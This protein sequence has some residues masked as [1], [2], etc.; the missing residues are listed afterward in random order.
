[1]EILDDYD[2]E[3]CQI[4]YN[5]VNEDVQ[6]GTKGL[7]YAAAKGLGVIVMEPLFGGTLANPPQPV[8]EIWKIST[9][10]GPPTWP[11]GGSGTS[12]RCRWSSAA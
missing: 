10:V 4:Q 2:W 11:C 6:A 3:F 5:F 12:P 9:S 8:W 7:Q 1:M